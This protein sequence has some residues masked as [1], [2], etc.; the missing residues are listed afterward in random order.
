MHFTR[1]GEWR[2]RPAVRLAR[3]SAPTLREW[4]VVFIAACE[5]G[6]LPFGRSV[7][8]GS[9]DG[10]RDEERRVAYVA[11]SRSQVQVYLKVFCYR[12]KEANWPEPRRGARP[13]LA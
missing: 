11:L 12:L 7:A 9:D 13:A 1:R 10:D 3:R 4:P 2:N 6:L 8:T 5:E